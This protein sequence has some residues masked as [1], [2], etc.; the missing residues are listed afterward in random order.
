MSPATAWQ[1]AIVAIV[2][3]C[4]A[5]PEPA[6]SK[7]APALTDAEIAAVVVAANETDAVMGEFA[8]ART[9]NAE[10]RAFANTMVRDHRAVNEQAGALVTRLGITPAAS[11]L[12]AKLVQSGEA[13]REQLSG[14]SGA[15]FD[16]SYADHEIGY[17]RAVID[18]VDQ[19]LL[20][21]TTNAELRA[22]IVGVRPA[23]VAHLQHA[24]Q[25]QASLKP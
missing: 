15:D 2:A 16:R 14:K 4:S 17:H 6:A 1:I 20:P 19:V 18:A 3:G 23:L 5:Q 7:A 11:A 10:V 21:A 12:S 24:E 25:L 13:A 22:A 9:S 8:A